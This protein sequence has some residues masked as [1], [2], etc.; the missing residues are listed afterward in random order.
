MIQESDFS[1]C[2][3]EVR[4]DVTPDFSGFKLKFSEIGPIQV[5][6]LKWNLGENLSGMASLTTHIGL[7]EQLS[8]PGKFQLW[9]F[10]RLPDQSKVDLNS[11]WDLNPQFLTE[12]PRIRYAITARYQKKK[13]SQSYLPTADSRP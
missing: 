2:S 11:Y 5:Q 13:D 4:V 1:G 3:P 6:N 7:R 8:V 12:G 9:G 10:A